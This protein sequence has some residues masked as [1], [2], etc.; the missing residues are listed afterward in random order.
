[1]AL[2]GRIAIPRFFHPVTQRGNHHQQVRFE[3][4]EYALYK[5]F[6]WLSAVARR[7]EAERRIGWL[8]KQTLFAQIGGRLAWEGAT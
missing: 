4:S 6:C 7:A 3:P 2:I 1:M 5:H 8:P